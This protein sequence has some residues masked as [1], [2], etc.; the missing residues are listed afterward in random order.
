[1]VH[2]FPLRNTKQRGWEGEGEGVWRW[3]EGKEPCQREK[4][5]KKDDMRDPGR[6]GWID[7]GEGEEGEQQLRK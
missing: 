6:H 7:G 3:G 2:A 5:D 4:K 1:M